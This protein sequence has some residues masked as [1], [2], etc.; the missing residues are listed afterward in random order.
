MYNKINNKVKA[1]SSHH[2]STLTTL[3]IHSTQYA[4]VATN[5]RVFTVATHY[6][7]WIQ[8]VLR[9]RLTFQASS[10]SDFGCCKH[11]LYSSTTTS[12]GTQT[13]NRWEWKTVGMTRTRGATRR[14]VDQPSHWGYATF[15]PIKLRFSA[16]L[17]NFMN[18]AKR[19]LWFVNTHVARSCLWG[20]HISL[21]SLSRLANYK[22]P[23]VAACI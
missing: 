18:Q 9:T 16:P 3:H 14:T 20:F 15:S 6:V 19:D 11:Q 5:Q 22:F 12:R 1:T 7:Y 21:E 23:R 13:Q 17:Y 2:I 10:S 4:R 8:S